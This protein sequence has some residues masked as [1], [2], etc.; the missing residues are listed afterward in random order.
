MSLD[1]RTQAAMLSAVPTLRQF[2]ISLCRNADRADDLVQDTLVRAIAHIDS[3]RPGTNLDAWLVTILRNRFFSVCREQNRT[4]QDVDGTYAE[5]LESVP[6]QVGWSIA[7]DLRESLQKL[8][9][10]QRQA[11]ILVGGSG[12][13]YEEAAVICKCEVGT[14]KSRVHR[15]RIEL[16]SLMSGEKKAPRLRSAPRASAV[17]HAA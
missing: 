8:E 7:K 17:M 2:A 6:E 14:V 16:A 3:F 15:A 5:S 11:L 9:P 1:P 13:S 10:N 4:V 12:L